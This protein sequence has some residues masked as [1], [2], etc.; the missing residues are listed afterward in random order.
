MKKILL[1]LCCCFLMFPVSAF[2]AITE[3]SMPN[4][5]NVTKDEFV[6]EIPKGSNGTFYLKTPSGSTNFSYEGRTFTKLMF[7]NSFNYIESTDRIVLITNNGKTLELPGGYSAI[8]IDGDQMRSLGSFTSFQ[9]KITVSNLAHDATFFLKYFIGEK[10]S[11]PPPTGGG[12]DP[13]PGDGTDPGGGSGTDPDPG[14]GTDP[15]GTDSGGGTDPGTGSGTCFCEAV[16]EVLPDILGSFGSS[17]DQI[18]GELSSLNGAMAPVHDMLG[19]I[20]DNTNRLH[21]DN[22]RLENV[23]GQIERDVA[24]LHD[25]LG[26]IQGQLSEVLRQITPTKNYDLPDPVRTPNYFDPGQASPVYRNNQTYF[27]DQGDAAA[28][29]SMPAAPEPKQWEFEGKKIDQAPEIVSSPIQKR[30]NEMIQDVEQER[31]PEMEKAEDQQR[32]EEMELSPELERLPE[33]K[34]TDPLEIEEQNF[35]LRWDSSE[36]VR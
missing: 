18:R 9:V 23:L 4:N 26:V 15:G 13:D 3:N 8:D 20:W 35:P 32:D 5:F 36:Y 24:P 33:L 30:D 7:T 6:A 2:A 10:G 34:L 29:G 17:L 31:S 11:G 21:D 12:T 25:D 19:R 14:G 28:P 27:R 1:I 16:C 22:L